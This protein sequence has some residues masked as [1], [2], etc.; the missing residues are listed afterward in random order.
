MKR[1]PIK[2]RITPAEK[3]ECE[4]V[5]RTKG[6]APVEL[7]KAMWQLGT[8]DAQAFLERIG[9]SMDSVWM[10]D[11]GDKVF[12]VIDGERTDV[13]EIEMIH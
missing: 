8:A 3:A 11:E 12:L 5:L 13:A 4:K 7:L 9:E 2:L 6:I 10:E 1:I